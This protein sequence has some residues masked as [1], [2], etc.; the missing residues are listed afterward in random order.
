MSCSIIQPSF[1]LRLHEMPE[2]ELEVDALAGPRGVGR[3]ADQRTLLF[4]PRGHAVTDTDS[5]SA[6]QAFAG[7]VDEWFIRQDLCTSR[8]V[9]SIVRLDDS[10]R[11]RS[12]IGSVVII[13]H[14]LASVFN[15][16]D[17]IAKC[18]GQ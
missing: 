2:Q 13:G 3:Q 10:C 9:R 17:V 4:R 16:L 11:G 14:M 6:H 12:N 18:H 1:T 7:R 8:L 15:L 5:R